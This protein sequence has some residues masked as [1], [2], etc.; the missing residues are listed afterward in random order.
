MG[1]DQAIFDRGL[2]RRIKH[3]MFR[4]PAR[5]NLTIRRITVQRFANHYRRF[6]MLMAD[7]VC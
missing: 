4:R 3:S 2:V 1:P 7:I 6:K 5:K